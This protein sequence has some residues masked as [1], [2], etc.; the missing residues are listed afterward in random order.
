METGAED[1]RGATPGGA[2]GE[3]NRVVYVKARFR[4]HWVEKSVLVPAGEPYRLFGRFALPR[5]RR[6]RQEVKIATSDCEIDGER[7]AEDVRAAVLA[8]NE[9]GY[10]VVTVTE[11]TSGQF[12]PRFDRASRS[13]RSRLMMRNAMRQIGYGYSHTEGV[14]IV[15]AQRL[16]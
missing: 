5:W 2:G 1:E 9:Q 7:L 12:S 16:P 13:S 11:V 4:E 8:L 15:A 14:V 6:T 3:H 10:A